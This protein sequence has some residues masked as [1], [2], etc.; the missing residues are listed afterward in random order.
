MRGA[1]VAVQNRLHLRQLTADF[2]DLRSAQVRGRESRAQ[3][4]EQLI[5]SK[6]SNNSCTMAWATVAY[7]AKDFSHQFL[8]TCLKLDLENS[9]GISSFPLGLSRF[10]RTTQG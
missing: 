3:R 9:S 2:G 7:S 5:A 4:H 1:G 10:A 6:M 8:A